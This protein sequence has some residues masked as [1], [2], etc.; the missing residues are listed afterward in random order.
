MRPAAQISLAILAL[1]TAWFGCP[2]LAIADDVSSNDAGL[3]PIAYPL[4]I[5]PDLPDSGFNQPLMADQLDTSENIYG[6]PPVVAPGNGGAAHL[7]LDVDY[8]DRYVYRG[9]DHDLVGNGGSSANAQAD[10]SLTFDL[11]RYPH[12]IMGVFTNIYTSDPVSV[13]QEFRPYIGAIW[14]PKPFLLE[15]LHTTYIYP[16]RQNFNTNEISVKFGV[17]DSFILHTQQPVLSPYVL[18]AYDYTHN[19]GWYIEGGIS[20]DIPLEDIGVV[21]KAHACAAY[22]IGYQQQ[23]VIVNSAN[24]TGWHHYELGLTASYSLN[25]LLNISKSAGEFDVKGF[26]NY[27]R[28]INRNISAS[29][30]L[31]GGVGIEFSY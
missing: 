22:I 12:P 21:L 26:L 8:A 17:D 15:V 14:T 28:K 2:T 7:N 6:P 4:R 11:G 19:H 20:Y 16:Q 29:N 24:D 1:T 10:A 25:T 30:V 23:F 5:I 13:F 9:L 18:G 31:W 27:D 3:G